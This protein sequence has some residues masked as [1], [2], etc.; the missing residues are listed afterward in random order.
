MA[1]A[2][3]SLIPAVMT[4]DPA[5]GKDGA[6]RRRIKEMEAMV[7]D[8]VVETPDTVTLVLF[9]GN[10]RLEYQPGHFLTI[11]PHQFQELS[12]FI[13]F[14]EDAKS[15]K[16]APRAYSLA[17]EPGERYLAITVKEERYV[18]GGTKYPPLLSPLLVHGIP[19]GTHMVITGFTGPYVLPPDPEQKTDHLVHLV[20]GSGSVPNLSILKH[21]LREYPRIRHTVVYSN[22]TW[23]DVIYRDLLHRLQ[24][25]HPDRL[26]VVHTLTREEHPELH[27]PGVRKGRISG[28]LLRE[29]IPDP[30]ACLVYACGPAVGPLEREAAKASGVPPAPRFLESALA[31]ARDAGVPLDR[32]KRESWG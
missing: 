23:A 4:R 9:T 20:A 24:A 8:V 30:K 12:R 1:D 11:D 32:V 13:A 10:E 25:E 19:R 21:A 6:P 3:R 7:A 5:V 28:A 22:K 18:S 16:E 14:F 31:A 29:V 15:R 17:S 26:R 27:G 2:T